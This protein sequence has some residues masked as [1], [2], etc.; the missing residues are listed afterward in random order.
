M[1]SMHIPETVSTPLVDFDAERRLLIVK[2]QSFPEDSF[3]F[4]E[5]V[6]KWL[7]GYVTSDANSQLQVEFSL[8]YLNTSSSKCIMLVLDTL[9]KAHSD[10]HRVQLKWLCNEE[11][12]FEQE[13][14]EEFKEDYTFP[15]EI[16]LI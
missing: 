14:A 8:T 7:N 10:G 12:E 6:L 11:N 9:E 16:A 13:C 1:D 3:K 5:P 15:F 4:Y 2:G